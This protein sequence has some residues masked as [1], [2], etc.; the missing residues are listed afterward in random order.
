MLGVNPRTDTKRKC[1]EERLDL[2]HALNFFRSI[3]DILGRIS[4]KEKEN[5]HF[6]DQSMSH[7]EYSH[8]LKTSQGKYIQL[9]FRYANYV[10]IV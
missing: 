1:V 10:L 9:Q 4:L 2:L 7:F 5:L 8:E 6:V 3:V